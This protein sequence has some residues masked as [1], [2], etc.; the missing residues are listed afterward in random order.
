MRVYAIS[1]MVFTEVLCVFRRLPTLSRRQK[2]VLAENA[3]YVQNFVHK[4]KVQIRIW[5]KSQLLSHQQWHN[6]QYAV[7]LV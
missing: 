3:D 1:E 7:T 4:K 5:A 2:K 6:Y